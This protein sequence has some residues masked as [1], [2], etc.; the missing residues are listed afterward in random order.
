MVGNDSPSFLTVGLSKR[1]RQVSA[2]VRSCQA[3]PGR[4]TGTVTGVVGSSVEGGRRA[5]APGS[6]NVVAIGPSKDPRYERPGKAIGRAR[7]LTARAP[8]LREDKRLLTS[9]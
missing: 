3:A 6:C 2:V 5:R 1:L 9:G 8:T 4:G 7:T